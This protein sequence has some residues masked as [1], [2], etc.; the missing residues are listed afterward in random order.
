METLL[1]FVAPPSPCGYLPDRLWSL[2]YDVVREARPAEYMQRLKEGWRRFGTMLFRPRCPGCRACQSLRVAV[3]RFRP[4][5][6]Q[7]RACQANESEV[8]L[9]I[10]APSVTE[11]KLWLYDEYHDYQAVSKGWPEHPAKDA[12][13]YA[14][15]FVHNPFVTEEWCYFLD[16]T[17]IGVGYVDALPEGLSAI[18]YFYDP[19]Q[20]RRSLG[21]WNVLRL[22]EE[23]ARRGLPHLYLGYYVEGCASLAYKASFVPNEVVGPD[24]QWHAFRE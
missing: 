13:S 12:D 23:T 15:S 9:V 7:R 10:T 14:H 6:S 8:K 22:I 20:R 19:L 24:G 3:D 18:Y 16:E 21:T 2:E 5:R 1:S 11:H 17:L 4:N